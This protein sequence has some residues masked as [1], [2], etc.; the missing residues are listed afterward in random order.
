MLI[1]RLISINLLS[2]SCFVFPNMSL[3]MANVYFKNWYPSHNGRYLR[4]A[5]V[6][7]LN[8]PKSLKPSFQ[9]EVS[10]CQR[11]IPLTFYFALFLHGVR[12]III[13]SH[14][15]DIHLIIYLIGHIR[16]FCALAIRLVRE[17]ETIIATLIVAPHLLDKTRTEVSRHFLDESSGSS[18][19]LQRIR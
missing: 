3:S 2:T 7:Y 10:Q 4:R 15:N 11:W 5:P 17:Q 16:P 18:K 12:T 9:L 14:R 8:T 6:M 19:A 13:P 1:D